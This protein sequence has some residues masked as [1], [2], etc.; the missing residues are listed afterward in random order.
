MEKASK[1]VDKIDTILSCIEAIKM[2]QHPSNE[3][4]E[5]LCDADV[6]HIGTPDLFYKKLL[7]RR[8]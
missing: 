8:G 6:F 5:A 4:T 1:P 7:L 3:Y 2:P